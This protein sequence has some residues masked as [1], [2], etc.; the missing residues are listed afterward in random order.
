MT[1][2]ASPPNRAPFYEMRFSNYY[3]FFVKA[4]FCL[5]LIQDKL[6]ILLQLIWDL[7]ATRKKNEPSISCTAQQRLALMG[8]WKQ[9]DSNFI[10]CNMNDVYCEKPPLAYSEEENHTRLMSSDITDVLSAILFLFQPLIFIFVP[11]FS[12]YNLLFV[13]GKF[14]FFWF[15]FT[16]SNQEIYCLS[17]YMYIT[18]LLHGQSASQ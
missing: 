6:F 16:V 18:F 2:L 10:F 1:S 8:H 5:L 12:F 17:I 11:L 7:L 14:D 13:N 4:G 15:L 3:I 9:P